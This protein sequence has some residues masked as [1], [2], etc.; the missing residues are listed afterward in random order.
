MKSLSFGKDV[1]PP[2]YDYYIDDVPEIHDDLEVTSGS[3]VS[4]AT[5]SS[6]PRQKISF[7]EILW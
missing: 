1:K 5:Q 3:H 2:N 7:S 6:L 4:V